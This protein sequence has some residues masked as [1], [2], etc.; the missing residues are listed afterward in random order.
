MQR[1][2]A[3][4]ERRRLPRHD[5]R[6]AAALEMPHL[7]FGAAAG[8]G[9]APGEPFCSSFFGHYPFGNC[10]LSRHAL[11]DVRHVRL[12]VSPPDLTVG[13]QPRTPWDLEHRSVITARVLLPD[14]Y[15]LGVCAAHLDHKAEELRERQM[16]RILAHCRVCHHPALTAFAPPRSVSCSCLAPARTR[17]SESG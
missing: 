13:S 2:A 17:P 6:L 5:A 1:H 14:G 12:R 9:D 3:L 10:I 11:A 8:D 7:A 16:S 15:M 4:A